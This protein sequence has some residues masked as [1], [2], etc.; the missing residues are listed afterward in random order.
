MNTLSSVIEMV[1]DLKSYIL[2]KIIE[3]LYIFELLLVLEKEQIEMIEYRMLV[4]IP[5]LIPN[6]T[7][8][9]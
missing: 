5:S 7:G 8:S 4:A 3:S 2:V 6:Q 1:K 9:C